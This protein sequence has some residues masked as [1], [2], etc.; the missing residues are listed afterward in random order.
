MKNAYLKAVF[1]MA[2]A[3]FSAPTSANDNADALAQKLQNPVASLISV[4][5]QNNWDFGIGATDA[6]RYTVNVQPVIPFKLNDD[7]NLITRTIVPIIHAESPVA[8]GDSIS[9]MGDI[10]QSFFLSP[11]KPTTSG[12]IWGAGPVFL[13]PSAT[14][15]RL[16]TEKFGLG[17]TAV[18]LRQQGPWT[19]GGLV[20]HIW[21]VTG[22]KQRSDVSGTFLNPFL[23]YTTS[24]QTTYSLSTE[25]TYDWER[26][27]WLVPMQAGVSQLV[28]FGTQPVQ[29][30]GSAR[31]YAEVPKGGS[32]WGLR[33]SV[34]LLFPK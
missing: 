28:M 26:N 21:S 14:D 22:N 17:P 10:V 18:L 12:I 33:F 9:G 15:D 7:I 1:L 4:P 3:A 20:N 8:G 27:Q 19:Y 5:I 24:K 23:S 11:A 13:Y 16:G 6:M 32:E 30:S 2:L 25:S 29:F 34:T 31:Y